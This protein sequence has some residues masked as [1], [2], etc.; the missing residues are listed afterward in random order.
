MDQQE[1]IRRAKEVA[2]GSSR[3]LSELTGISKATIDGWSAPNYARALPD[4]A[5]LALELI[6]NV[7]AV[8]KYLRRFHKL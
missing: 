3:A 7:P 1:L 2:G 5:R 4:G 8:L 6:V